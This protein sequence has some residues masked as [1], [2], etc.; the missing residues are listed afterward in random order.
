MTETTPREDLN[1]LRVAIK[2]ADVISTCGIEVKD[3]GAAAD[4]FWRFAS[5]GAG[6]APDY[7]PSAETRE[8][9][10][11][12]LIDR[13]ATG[14]RLAKMKIDARNYQEAKANG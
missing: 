10:V 7:L 12:L 2:L 14:E 5:H 3:M 9:T 1:R 11:T 8:V 4:E 13:E 6:F